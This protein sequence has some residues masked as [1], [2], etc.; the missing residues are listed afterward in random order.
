MRNSA[1]PNLDP[2]TSVLQ[3]R[4]ASPVRITST[5]ASGERELFIPYASNTASAPL[6][7]SALSI[8]VR[9]SEPAASSAAITAGAIGL[10][11]LQTAPGPSSELMDA[12]MT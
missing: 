11:A 10:P 8:T 3:V 7:P 9:S 12:K 2:E 4:G 5:P 6:T 1:S